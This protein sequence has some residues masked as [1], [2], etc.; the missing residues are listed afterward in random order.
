MTLS[1]ASR[2]SFSVCLL[3]HNALYEDIFVCNMFVYFYFFLILPFSCLLNMAL[4]SFVHISVD[5][6]EG[7]IVTMLVVFIVCHS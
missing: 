7:L 6:G 2:M 3:D 5:L 4:S 1:L